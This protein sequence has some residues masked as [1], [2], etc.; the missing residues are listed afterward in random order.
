MSRPSPA[1]NPSPSNNPTG[2]TPRPTSPVKW[3]R[4]ANPVPDATAASPSLSPSTDPPL[5]FS[6]STAPIASSDPDVSNFD[7][8]GSLLGDSLSTGHIPTS[9]PAA[10][11][12]SSLAGSISHGFAAPATTPG[13]PGTTT[14]TT[15]PA[16]PPLASGTATALAAAVGQSLGDGIRPMTMPPAKSGTL[17]PGGGHTSGSI[18]PDTGSGGDGPPNG[19]PPSLTSGTFNIQKTG[20]GVYKAT[21]TIPIGAVVS[22]TASLTG[23]TSWAWTNSV[24]SYAGYFNTLANQA[25]NPSQPSPTE[26]VANANTYEF[27]VGP[28]TNQQY[29]VTCE[30][31]YPNGSGTATLTFTSV[32]PTGSLSVMKPMPN[33]IAVSNA[34]PNNTLQASVGFPG[35]Q[36]QGTASL[37]N[38]PAGQFM[39]MQILVTV[40]QDYQDANGVPWFRANNFD[41]DN[42]D[43]DGPLIDPSPAPPG[44]PPGVVVAD[45]FNYTNSQGTLVT[46]N[47]SWSLPDSAGNTSFPA[48]GATG[49][50]TGDAPDYTTPAGAQ[51]MQVSESFSDYLM[52]KANMQGS[53][54]IAISQITWSWSAS[55]TQGQGK[56]SNPM[57]QPGNSSPPSGI[58]A[59]PGWVNTTPNLLTTD[60]QQGD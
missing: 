28:A 19:T 35:I 39:F 18:S 51:N 3:E 2:E 47:T 25:P 34:L 60:V 29:K 10:Q 50:Y 33:V 56:T 31:T 8:A 24:T 26:P 4:L 22:L 32:V 9:G 7:F 11:A 45:L 41:F 5:T 17:Q 43:F 30:A 46:N 59:F 49:Y 23:T 57:P 53:V 6:N 1:A 15:V 13:A 14:P 16:S 40:N 38:A 21:T 42:G 12:R 54:W 44:Q 52:Y 37:G 20:L 58:A 36:I 48:G 55:V 27:I